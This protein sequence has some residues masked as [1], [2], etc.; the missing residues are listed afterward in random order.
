MH[1]PPSIPF[2][3]DPLHTKNQHTEAVTTLNDLKDSPVTNPY[4][5]EAILPS[6]QDAASVSTRLAKLP[7]VQGVLS[8]NT[9]VPEDQAAKLAIIADA[10]SIL[11]PTLTP[12]A[13]PPAVTPADLRRAAHDLDVRLRATEGKLGAKLAADDPLRAIEKDL[14]RLEMTPDAEMMAANNALIRFLP[15]SSTACAPHSP[16]SQSPSPTCRTS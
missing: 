11:S 15:C 9:F 5:I 6:L 4:T 10:A 16:P 1:S 8:L 12:P 2:D 14:L 7:T 3:G 13:T